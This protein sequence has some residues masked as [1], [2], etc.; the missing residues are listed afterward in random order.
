MASHIGKMDDKRTQ[1]KS[2]VNL[3][4]PLINYLRFKSQMTHCISK[5]QA[6]TAKEI[7]ERLPECKCK[8]FYLSDIT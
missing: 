8:I 6:D 1:P 5:K 7:F 2:L 4:E 3:W